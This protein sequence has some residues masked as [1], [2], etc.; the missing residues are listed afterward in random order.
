MLA[1]G[2]QDADLDVQRRCTAALG[3]LLFYVA[4]QSRAA[5][6]AGGSGGGW[7]AAGAEVEGLVRTLTEGGRDEVVQVCAGMGLDV[8]F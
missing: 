4:S 5:A 8:D 1:G 2:M 3:E 7:A 6:A